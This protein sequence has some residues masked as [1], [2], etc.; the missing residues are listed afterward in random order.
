VVEAADPV[1]WTKPDDLDAAPGKPFPALG[2]P[3]GSG[4]RCSAVFA[5]A[6]TRRLRLDLP[7]TRL[8]AL[9]THSG[10][11]PLPPGWHQ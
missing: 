8:R 11:E 4:G 10:G 9:V 7:E 6:Q 3:K 1:E 2:G 5:D